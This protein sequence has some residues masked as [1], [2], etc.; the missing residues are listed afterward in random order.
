MP[1]APPSKA[2]ALLEDALVAWLTTVDGRGRPQSSPV[3]FVMENGEFLV[4]SLA[5]TARI[6]NI[7]ANPL[8]SVNLDSNEGSDVVIAEGTAR[9]VDGPPSTEHGAYQRKYLRQIEGMGY[10]AQTF[11]EAYPTPI[12]IEPTRWRSF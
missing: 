6:R 7:R 9:I 2:A 12:R 1:V 10:S 11:A 3:W 8:V 4:Y 5:D